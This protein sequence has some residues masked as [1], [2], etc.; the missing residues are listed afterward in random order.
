M[1]NFFSGES[2]QWLQ[3]EL[4]EETSVT[5]VVTQGSAVAQEWVAS[6]QVRYGNSTDVPEHVK[7]EFGKPE[8]RQEIHAYRPG[9]LRLSD[10]SYINL[11]A[12]FIE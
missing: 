12:D 9:S 6:F 11:F 3:I 1:Q 7:D 2:G 10:Q 5:G 8:V 4:Q